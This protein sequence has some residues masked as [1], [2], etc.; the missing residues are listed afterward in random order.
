MDNTNNEETVTVEVEDNVPKTE[1]TSPIQ[2]DLETRTNVQEKEPEQQA[3]VKEDEHEEYTEKVQ[4]RINQL[5]AK[6]KQAIEEAQA[7]Y[8]YAQEMQKENEAM[9]SRLANLDK[10]YV[11]EFGNR[12]E[13]QSNQAKEI[14]KKAIEDNDPEKI[15]QAQEI[16]AELAFDKKR[17]QMQ[18][19]KQIQEEE[20]QKQQAQQPKQEIQKPASKLELDPKLQ[21]WMSE[22]EWFTKDKIMTGYVRGLHEKLVLEDGFD[23]TSDE[24][25]KEIDSTM[26]KIF[27]EKFQPQRNNAQSVAPASSGR[28]IKSG[29]KKT[30]ELNP[31]QVAFAN[32]MKIPIDRYAAEVA[33]IEA[34]RA[35]NGR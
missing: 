1:I 31:G 26:R 17:V 9:K 22:N 8:S 24:Y 12:V 30:V 11:A 35:Q 4:K 6:R 20:L 33:K 15:A 13:S 16:I 5:T 18:Q 32:K 27:P 28:S 10:G 7:A 14:L 29:R 2:V 25:Y 23:P 19:Q 21:N 3:A 34:R